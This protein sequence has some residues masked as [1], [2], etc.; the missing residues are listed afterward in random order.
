MF[1]A[2]SAGSHGDRT[3]IA[4]EPLSAAE[5]RDRL[6]RAMLDLSVERGFRNIDLPALLEHAGVDEAAFHRHF[7]DLEDCFVAKLEE[8]RDEFFRQLHLA[9][10][11]K[12]L[13]VDRLRS[14]AYGLLR[15]LRADPKRRHFLTAELSGAG[16]RATRVWTETIVKPLFDLIDEGRGEGDRPDSQTR[17][18]AEA[19]GGG[20]FAQI[21]TAAERG[22]L[23]EAAV[24]KLMYA[25]V[26]PY[27]GADAAAKELTIPPP[28]ATG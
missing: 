26:L 21:N 14:A 16:E 13:W 28:P 25:A 17:A 7:G 1:I 15:F 11:G 2:S 4:G 12:V 27:L 3:R 10:E 19:V 24:P 18:T 22:T 8:E 9:V 20:I 23:D 5:E 6:L